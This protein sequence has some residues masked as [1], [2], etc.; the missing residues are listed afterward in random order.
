METSQIILIYH[1][2]KIPISQGMLYSTIIHLLPLGL[3][4]ILSP[5]S[6]SSSFIEFDSAAFGHW[7]KKVAAARATSICASCIPIHAL[8]E[9]GT[10]QSRSK[11]RI[12]TSSANT[13]GHESFLHLL[14]RISPS[15]GDK[16]ESVSAHS[17]GDRDDKRRDYLR[18]SLKI[19]G[20]R[21]TVND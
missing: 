5:N 3:M 21:C 9:S 14:S 11:D 10:S 12:L 20:F 18:G 7:R 1:F 2:P 13:K 17:Q 19:L 15:L 4:T 8:N 16:S 6:M